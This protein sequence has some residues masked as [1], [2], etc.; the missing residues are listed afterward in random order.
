MALDFL[1]DILGDAYTED[2]G[3]RVS[4]AVGKSFVAKNDFDAKNSE[5]KAARAQLADAAKT[6]EGLQAEGKDLAAVRREAAEYK[7]RAEQAEKDAA[8][9]LEEYKFSTWPRTRAATRTSSAR[10]QVKNGCRR[11]A[12]APTGTRKQRPCLSSCRKTARMPS[13]I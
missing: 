10:W 9:Q 11:C 5:L 12:P 13:R 7:A 1:K 4:E 2:I 3:A 6:I 8:A